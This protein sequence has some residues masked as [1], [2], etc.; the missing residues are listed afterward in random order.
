MKED[1]LQEE[2]F[3]SWEVSCLSILIDRILYEKKEEVYLNFGFGKYFTKTEFLFQ[4]WQNNN[5]YDLKFL[6]ALIN[7]KKQMLNPTV[8]MEQ[9]KT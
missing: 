8:K 3:L 9:T 2:V 1:S 7:A 6:I 5:Y 4:P